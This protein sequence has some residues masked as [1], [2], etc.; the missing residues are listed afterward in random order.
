M[1]DGRKLQYMV[2]FAVSLFTTTMGMINSW[3]LSML[4][5]FW[6]SQTNTK[7]E[8]V[9]S[10]VATTAWILFMTHILWTSSW[11]IMSSEIEPEFQRMRVHAKLELENPNTFIDFLSD[12]IYRKAVII[13]FGLEL[14]F[15]LSGTTAIPDHFLTILSECKINFSPWK[16]LVLDVVIK[17]VIGILSALLI[18][19]V[20]RRILLLSSLIGCS[21]SMA[22]M[23][24]FFAERYEIGS[25]KVY[26][27][28]TFAALIVYLIS[29]S[30]R[31]IKDVIQV[32]VF[33][34]NIRAMAVGT[35]YTL[36]GLDYAINNGFTN[37]KIGVF[38]I[39]WIYA[40]VACAGYVFTYY[41]LPETKGL[42]LKEV[43]EMLRG[44]DGNEHEMTDNDRSNR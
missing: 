41:L 30:L 43:Q 32:E 31:H 10:A 26:G 34:L 27:H 40:A 6:Y 37:L 15:L 35:L 44:G 3:T 20:G 17:I 18:D 25:L 1:D 36:E 12:N 14:I 22:I 4:M 21:I 33:P 38:V 5:K 39:Y 42:S 2:A 7:I 16:M 23:G 24:L 29:T 28:I 19:I 8:D 11:G 9:L 13:T